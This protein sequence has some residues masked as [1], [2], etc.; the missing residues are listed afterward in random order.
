MAEA[1]EE[2]E[3][4][5]MEAA[6]MAEEAVDAMGDTMGVA[7]GVHRRGIAAA[8]PRNDVALP[9]LPEWLCTGLYRRPAMSMG[10]YVWAYMNTDVDMRCT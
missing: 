5:A 1:E 3:V 7:M 4:A 10:S 2:R 8:G 6:A 9:G